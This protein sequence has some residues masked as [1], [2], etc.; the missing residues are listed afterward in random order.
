MTR[1]DD[2]A[3]FL[4]PESE[5]REGDIYAPNLDKRGYNT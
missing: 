1:H 2:V 3:G 4:L 5:M